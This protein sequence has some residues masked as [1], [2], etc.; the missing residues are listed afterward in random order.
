MKDM[1]AMKQ[2][3]ALQDKP[4]TLGEDGSCLLFL[5]HG[6]PLVVGRDDGIAEIWD[7]HREAHPNIKTYGFK[8]FRATS[9]N[10]IDKITK[11]VVRSKLHMAQKLGDVF[12]KHYRNSDHAEVFKAQKQLWADVLKPM[13]LGQ[14][15]AESEDQDGE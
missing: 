15:K 3:R 8:A 1:P 2:M 5:E 12:H 13:T 6:H 14:I 4:N 11:N 7:T 9:A 10:L